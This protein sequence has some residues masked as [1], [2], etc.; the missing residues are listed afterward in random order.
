MKKKLY[1]NHPVR[2]IIVSPSGS[3]KTCFLTQLI[4]EFINEITEIYI[5]SPS[6]HQDTYQILIECFKSKI[7][8]KSI[9][10]VLQNK[11][12][13]EDLISDE[14]FEPSNQIKEISAHEKIDELKYPQEYTGKSTAI[15]L[16]DLNEKKMNDII[17]QALFKRSRIKNIS[18]F[19]VSQDYYELPKRTI[20]A[21]CNIFHLFKPN[22]ARDVQNLFQDKASMNM[23]FSEFKM[24]C[25]NC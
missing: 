8:I 10:K 9:N 15:I 6:I 16:D 14:N 11:K 25:A 12:T 5:H 7:P 13:I 23:T 24:L 22:N 18:V 3:G 20:G 17:V 1:P 21:N 4:L 2:A 19:I